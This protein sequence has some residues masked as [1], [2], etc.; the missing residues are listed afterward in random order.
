MGSDDVLDGKRVYYAWGGGEMRFGCEVCDCFLV[1]LRIWWASLVQ[2][3]NALGCRCWD[4]FVVYRLFLFV[5]LF[6][7]LCQ[8]YVD[9]R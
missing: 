9:V 6:S 4:V 7:L 5:L 1:V 3:Y 2:L 8:S